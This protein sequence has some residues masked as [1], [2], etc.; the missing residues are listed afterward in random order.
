L[1]QV[2][3]CLGRH[4]RV[5]GFADQFLFGKAAD[6]DEGRVDV[7]DRVAVQQGY[8]CPSRE[9]A[10]D[11]LLDAHRNAQKRKALM[12]KTEAPPGR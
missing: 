9:I 10:P 11:M 12:K 3:K 4:V 7:D 8:R 2:G 1:I 5:V 6:V